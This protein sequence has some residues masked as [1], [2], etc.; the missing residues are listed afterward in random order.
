MKFII[1]SEAFARAAAD[2]IRAVPAKSALPAMSN[3]LMELDKET[4]RI[5]ATDGEIT[6]TGSVKPEKIESEGTVTVPA[7]ILLDLL[8]TLP[9][10]E[11][12][13]T[14][15]EQTLDLSWSSG[16]SRIP[17]FPVEEFPKTDTPAE[18][19]TSLETTTEVLTTAISKTIYAVGNEEIRPV[20]MGIFFDLNPGRSFIVASD[21]QKLVCHAFDTPALAAKASFVVPTK[22]ANILR[23]ILPKEQA[24]KIVFDGK[25]ALFESGAMRLTTRLIV[26]KFPNYRSIIPTKNSNVLVTNRE[27]LINALKR[28][29]V[30]ADRKTSLVKASLSYNK[31]VLEAQDLGMATRGTETI[32]CDYDGQDLTIGLKAPVISETFSNLSSES[33]EVAFLDERHAILIQPS[34]EDRKDEP[35]EAV[36]MPYKV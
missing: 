35:I 31:L 27:A 13:V 10:G 30:F 2:L 6:L 1:Q 20:L 11:V 22:S 28:M 24:V 18:D 15:E 4:L 34:E 32:E 33:I 7:K 16:C 5:T 14:S 8:K 9:S 21:A 25:N 17:T 19:A 23:G 12:T 29:S 3:F 36:V 26:G